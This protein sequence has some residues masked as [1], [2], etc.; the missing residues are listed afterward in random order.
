MDV[1]LHNFGVGFF[2]TDRYYASSTEY[3]FGGLAYMYMSE[4]DFSDG[5]VTSGNKSGPSMYIR[6][7]RKFN[8]STVYA[9]RDQGPAGGWIF[10]VT[11]LGGGLYEYYECTPTN[12][13]RST[14]SNITNVEVGTS[15]N[16]AIGMGPTNTAMIIAQPGHTDSAAKFCDDLIIYN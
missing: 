3:P 12:Y 6:P 14:W 4:R 16:S 15:A 8:S 11:S 2:N 7:A 9:L 1:E 10:R 5:S 13:V